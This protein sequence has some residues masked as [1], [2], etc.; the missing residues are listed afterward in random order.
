M[1]S[2]TYNIIYIPPLSPVAVSVKLHQ[3]RQYSTD[4]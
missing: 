1:C 3:V 4:W 2:I